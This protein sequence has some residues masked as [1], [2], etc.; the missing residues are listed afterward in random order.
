MAGAQCLRAGRPHE[1]RS[2]S[3]L[4]LRAQDAR[5]V[6]GRLVLPAGTFGYEHWYRSTGPNRS[7][8]ASRSM[9]GRGRRVPRVCQ[10]SLLWASMC[11]RRRRRSP[12]PGGSSLQTWRDRPLRKALQVCATMSVTGHRTYLGVTCVVDVAVADPARH[13]AGFLQASSN[14]FGS[15]VRVSSSAETNPLRDTPTR[16]GD[17]L[18]PG[19][20]PRGRW[21][22]AARSRSTSAF[23]NG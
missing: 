14:S 2:R 16:R 5:K 20:P 3:P 10:P 17:A 9:C 4:A 19:T 12:P 21:R 11:E 13:P 18:A 22:A 23:P 8:D 6:P 7:R 1:G 15:K